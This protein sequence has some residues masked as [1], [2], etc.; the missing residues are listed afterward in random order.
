MKS[1][2]FIVFILLSPLLLI[3]QNLEVEG[4]AK[5]TVMDDDT[6]TDSLVVL[7]P[8]GE[9]ARR[10][11]SSLPDSTGGWT[12][13]VDTTSTMNRVGIGTASPSEKLDI[14]GN[15]EVNGTIKMVDGVLGSGKVLTSDANGVGT[16]QTPIVDDAD[17]DPTNELQ[18]LSLITNTL[19]LSDSAPTVDLSP[20]LDNTDT[21]LTDGEIAALGYIKTFT[22]VDGS[23]TNELQDLSIATNT[24]SLTNSAQTIDLSPYLDNTDT[25]NPFQTLT[26][27]GATFT[28]SNQGVT[29]TKTVDTNTT[30]SNLSEFTNDVGYITSPNDAD[31]DPTNEY[32]TTVVLNG[33]DL[34]VTDGGGTITTDLSTLG[35]SSLWT[36]SGADTYLTSLTDNVGIGTAAPSTKLEILGGYTDPLIPGN[37]SNGILRIGAAYNDGLDIGKTGLGTFDAWLQSGFAGA[38]D[39]ISLQPLGGNVG[40]GLLS[41]SAKLEVEG[42]IKA[43]SLD[44]QSGLIKNVAD[45]ISAQ[46]AATKAYVDALEAQV[47]LLF[48]YL[49]NLITVQERLDLG[50]TPKH[51]FDSGIVI[52][53]IWGKTYQGGLIFYMNTTT[54][55]GYVSA[56]TDQSS[57]AEWGC[58]G[59]SIGGTSAAVGTGQANTTAIV[60]GCPTAGIAAR[61]CDDLVYGGYNDWFLPSKDELNEMYLKIGQGAAAPNTNIGGFAASFYWSSS[62]CGDFNAWIQDFHDGD[63]DLLDKGEQLSG[64]CYPGFLTIYQFNYLFIARKR[65][66]IILQ[67]ADLPVFKEVYQ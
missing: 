44:L 30:Y 60:N 27:N 32:N 48:S 4:K 6:T 53:S 64:A 42:G 62:E 21:Q 13:V 7:R 3:S 17:A 15:L 31:S 28:L 19:S 41:P 2:I 34:E 59:T 54:G 26:D 33:T 39:P 22:E 16:W 61:L 66:I 5:I 20:Y 58:F 10:H 50:E 43:D 1:L 11:V 56:A 38:A 14:V 8:G 24:L 63:Q 52:D 36:D 18:D 67:M 45:P 9:L 23:V 40:I 46:D 55:A 37:T 29:V 57:G 51:I 65:S 47:N 35:G 49:G 12:E 25:Q